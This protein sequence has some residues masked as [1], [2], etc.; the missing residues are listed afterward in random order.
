MDKL[1]P[2][3][4]YSLLKT[5][6]HNG[7][8]SRTAF[9]NLP[10]WLIKTMLF[11]PLRWYELIAYNKKIR[12]HQ[13]EKPPVFIL[14]YY[15]SG[16]TYLQQTLVQDARFGYLDNF[17][18]ILPEIM[19]STEG[20]LKP[21]L[22]GITGL[23]GVENK[24]HR[25]PL[26]WDFPAE[27][28]VAMTTAGWKTGGY[29]G[30][31]FPRM[32]EEQTKKYVLFKT[33]NEEEEYE[34][35]E[36]YIFLL[37]KISLA[38]KGKQLLLKTPPNTARVKQ[39]LAA[40]PG[41]RFIFIHRNPYDVYSSNKR[42]WKVVQEIYTLGNTD[43]LDVNKTIFDSYAAMMDNYISEKVYIPAGQLIEI[44]YADF[45]ADPISELRNIYEKLHLGDF[46]ECETRMA[47]FVNRKKDFAV[48]KHNLTGS[49][50]EQVNE[51]WGRYL[52]HWNYPHYQ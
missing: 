13:L 32:M 10:A 34:W 29:W 47:N 22:S 43:T 36:N 45:V 28:D 11:E 50:I 52:H 33:G 9:R 23:L 21:L 24:M 25:T 31:F 7:G 2:L 49:E 16:T 51:K 19:L 1:L 12:L 44:G 30:Y 41:A 26:T 39:L 5:A 37:K 14:G 48:L 15:R 42:L 46:R 6:A 38:N 20:W 8:F 40:F 27:E 17:Q 35:M 18:Q 4:L 3:P